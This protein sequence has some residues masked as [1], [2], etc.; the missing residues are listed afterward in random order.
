MKPKSLPLPEHLQPLFWDQDFGSLD[1]DADRNLIVRRI[2]QNGNWPAIKWLR[3]AWGDESLRIWLLAHA[4]GRLNPRQL[5]YWQLT[6]DLPSQDVDGWIARG[7]GN[8][9][10]RRVR[11]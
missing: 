1:W 5:R 2:L 10:E 7:K 4:G 11:R 3:S 6:L 9:W 8:P